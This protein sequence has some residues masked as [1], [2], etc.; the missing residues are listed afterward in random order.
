VTGIH[1]MGGVYVEELSDES[2]RLVDFENKTI[3]E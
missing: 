1:D 3:E 2:T